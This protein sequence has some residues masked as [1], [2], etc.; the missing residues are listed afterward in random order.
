MY[1]KSDC[2]LF[3]V[4]IKL[5]YVSITPNTNTVSVTSAS[6]DQPHRMLRINQR[7]GSHCICIF[8]GENVT[9]RRFL[10]YSNCNV[11]RTVGP[12]S[13][14]GAANPQIAKLHTDLQPREPEDMCTH[15]GKC[16]SVSCLQIP[17]C[18]LSRVHTCNCFLVL[19]HYSAHYYPF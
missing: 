7:V 6:G 8:Q 15:G 5:R 18:L 2:V 1:I 16:W 14:F 9:V 10:E 13:T 17:V 19:S 4:Y 12:F 3:L 11:F